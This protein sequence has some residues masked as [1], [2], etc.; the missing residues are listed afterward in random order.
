M[1]CYD[2]YRLIETRLMSTYFTFLCNYF[3]AI[4]HAP[5]TPSSP[6]SRP[7]SR[8]TPPGINRRQPLLHPLHNFPPAVEV[9]MMVVMMQMLQKLL[10]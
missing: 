4:H 9:V 2:E 1:G 7:S 10:R 3:V 5:T 6:A 8:R